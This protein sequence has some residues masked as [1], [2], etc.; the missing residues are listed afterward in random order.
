[1]K[2]PWLAAV[3]AAALIPPILVAVAVAR[4]AV[5]VPYW[6]Q[7]Q[8][9][10][11]L[12]DAARG[13]LDLRELWAQHNEHRLI[14]PRL[15][16]LALA[17]LTGWNVRWE[18]VACVLLNLITLGLLARTLVRAVRPSFPRLGPWLVVVA[19][20]LTF[21]PSQWEN[22]TSGWQCQMFLHVLFVAWIALLLVDWHGTWPRLC[23]ILGLA[24]LALGSFAAGLSVVAML[25]LVAAFCRI[26][27]TSA[28]ESAGRA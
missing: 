25:P 23:A 27:A 28:P 26:L 7:W 21:S 3:W 11:L 20:L 17:F 5:N 9:A 1:M 4:T 14:V 10:P 15:L 13:H 24:A 12:L 22:W 16:M 18:L 19:S 8:F 2:H 6:D